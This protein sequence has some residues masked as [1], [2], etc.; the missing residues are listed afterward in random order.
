MVGFRNIPTA[1][2]VPLFYAEVDPSRANTAQAAQRTLIV[3]QKLTSGAAVA[4]VPVRLQS[5]ADAKTQ[6]GAGSMLA[7]MAAAYLKN[8]PQAELWALPLADDGSAAAATGSIALTGPATAAGVLCVYV[9][10]TLVQIPVATAA[11]ASTVATALAAAVNALTDLPVTAAAA[12]G[13]VTFTARNKGLVGNDIDLRVNYLGSAA[14]EALPAGLGATVSAMASGA[15]NPSL[16][17]GLA[18]LGDQPFDFIVSPYNDST[19]TTALTAL[20][21][22]T[23]GRWSYAS[24]TY[25]GVFGAYAGTYGNQATFGAGLNDPHLCIPGI[26]DSPSWR[27]EWAAAFAGAAARSLKADPALPLQTVPILGVKAPPPASQLTFAQ[28]NALLYDGISTFTCGPDG[29][30]AI[31]AAITTYQKNGFNQ[32]DDAYLYVET[33]FTLQAV[34]RRLRGVVTSKYARA[35]I[36][37]SGARVPPGSAII[38]TDVIRADLIAEY[39]ATCD[40]G[41]TENPDAFAANLV[42][43]RDAQNPRRVNVL[44]PGDLID[45]LRTFAT[46]IQFRNY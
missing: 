2:R 30:V 21:N 25:G 44:W 37:A 11:T 31:E 43:E 24:Q 42:V 7:I 23:A 18:A 33:L 38:T 45:G 15:T 6:G 8:D 4:N 32:P 20:L 22:D 36:A 35:K 14:G 39:R 27:A 3:A 29:S 41:L 34:I 12:A 16:T 5:A 28:R 10:G 46:L 17:S 1:L 40:D 9:A 19:S 26:Y 13:T